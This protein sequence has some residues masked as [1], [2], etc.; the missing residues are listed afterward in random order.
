MT[1]SHGHDCCPK[2][3]SRQAP[4]SCETGSC[5]HHR[6]AEADAKA[7]FAAPPAPSFQLEIPAFQEEAP[8]FFEGLR[9]AGVFTASE[10]GTLP[11]P[12]YVLFRTLLI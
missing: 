12:L 9:S 2:Q 10:A 4:K 6:A 3:A 11:Q 7:E 1:A 5:L 8:A